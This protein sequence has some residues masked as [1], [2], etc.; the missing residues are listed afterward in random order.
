MTTNTGE[1]SKIVE[2]ADTAN[3]LAGTAQSTVALGSG[4]TVEVYKCKA[5]NVGTILSLALHIMEEMHIKTL[6]DLPDINMKDPSFFLQLISKTSDRLYVAAEELCGLSYEEILDLEL[7]DAIKLI[8]QVVTV[9]KDFF[10]Q[11]VMPILNVHLPELP[12]SSVKKTA[13]KRR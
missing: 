12:K 13:R 8:L 3:K 10:L 6:G 1:T 7:D 5:R 2:V 4:V 9:N 11:K